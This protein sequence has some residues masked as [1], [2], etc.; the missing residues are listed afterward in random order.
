MTS[1]MAGA[2]FR[3]VGS[4]EEARAMTA[5]TRGPLRPDDLKLV[6]RS[7]RRFVDAAARY[8]FSARRADDGFWMIT[9][10]YRVEG[11]GQKLREIMNRIDPA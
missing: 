1:P 6:I 9:S 5:A 3:Q 4:E 2:I 11:D 7:R 8:G 10:I